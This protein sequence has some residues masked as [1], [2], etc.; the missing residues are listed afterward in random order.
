MVYGA[1]V[2]LVLPFLFSARSDL[3][4]AAGFLV[5]AVLVIFTIYFG[6]IGIKKLCVLFDG[7]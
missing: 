2:G 6:I 1:V 7:Y 4:V 3:A 5:L